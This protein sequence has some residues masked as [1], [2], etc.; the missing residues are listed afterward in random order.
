M[1]LV[2]PRPHPVALNEQYQPLIDD[3]SFRHHVKPGLTG[4]AQVNGFRGENSVALMQKRVEF[5]RW[6]I[7]HWSLWLDFKITLR[8]LLIIVRQDDSADAPPLAPEIGS[9]NSDRRQQE[10]GLISSVKFV[11]RDARSASG[12]RT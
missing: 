1:S 6:Y 5:D 7:D 10:I 9:C 12:P 11:D 8:T 4:W 2:G 3:Y